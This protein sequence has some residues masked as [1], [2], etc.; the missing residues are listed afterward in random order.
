MKVK[1]PKA[2]MLRPTAKND[3]YNSSLEKKTRIVKSTNSKLFFPTFQIHP[4]LPLVF[5]PLQPTFES[6]TPSTKELLKGL[7]VAINIAN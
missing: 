6:N 2:A 7:K 3:K 5:P 1:K 4:F